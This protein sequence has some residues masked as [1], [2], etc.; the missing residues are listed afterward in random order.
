[1]RDDEIKKFAD[2]MSYLAEY[3][4]RGFSELHT[5]FY[6]NALEKYTF[7]D[8]KAAVNKHIADPDTGQYPPKISDLVRYLEGGSKAKAMQAWSK[9]LRAMREIGRYSSVVFDDPCIHCVIDE[10]GGWI[11]LCGVEVNELPFRA[12]EFEKRYAAY[13]IKAPTVFPKK[14]PG[15]LDKSEEPRMIGNAKQAAMVWNQGGE[16]RALEQRTFS[17]GMDITQRLV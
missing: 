6:W 1:M 12:A 7:D 4:N 13:L 9:V 16:V 3:Y 5:E 17:A 2:L 14:L 8:V 10:M 15:I 11:S